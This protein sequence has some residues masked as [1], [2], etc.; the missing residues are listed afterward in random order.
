MPARTSPANNL[1]VLDR[2]IQDLESLQY[3]D[4][5][6]L[7]DILCRAEAVN[8]WGKLGRWDLRV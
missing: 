7:A 5:P 1:E 2:L 3:A 6:G 4:Q 8:N